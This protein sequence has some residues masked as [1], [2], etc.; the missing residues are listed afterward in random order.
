MKAFTIVKLLVCALFLI[1]GGCSVRHIP[2]D[3]SVADQDPVIEYAAEY[4]G[5]SYYSGS[6]ISSP[7][8]AADAWRMSQYYRGGIPSN[9]SST[10]FGYQ[11]SDRLNIDPNPYD[12]YRSGE[13]PIM[14]APAQDSAQLKRNVT[15]TRKRTRSPQTSDWRRD[16]FVD[17]AGSNERQV[18][19]SLKQ[20]RQVENIDDDD[21]SSKEKS[22]QKTRK[23]TRRRK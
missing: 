19:R 17:Q 4:D 9:Q 15:E 12:N 14:R 23:R 11:P 1:A 21:G 6:S 8:F 7:R 18:R 20:R 10:I 16:R 5:G 3:Q 2:L 13:A 22:R